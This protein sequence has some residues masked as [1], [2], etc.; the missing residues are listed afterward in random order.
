MSKVFLIKKT[1]PEVKKEIVIFDK[2]AIRQAEVQ[3]MN[4]AVIAENNR[5]IEEITDYFLKTI[6]MFR[7][8]KPMKKGIVREFYERFPDISH[9]KIQIILAKHAESLDY[10][11]NVASGTHRYDLSGKECEK[12]RDIERAFSSEQILKRDS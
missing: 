3:K 12:I 10:L 7:E 8:K 1:K 9:R 6:P 2:K 11:K 4:D 5:Q